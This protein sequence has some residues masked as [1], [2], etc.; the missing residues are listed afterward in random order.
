MIG[1]GTGV[2]SAPIGERVGPG[3]LEIAVE[4]DP[5]FLPIILDN[6]RRTGVSN[7]CAVLR[8]Y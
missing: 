7:V 3:R 1:A 6:A 8:E 5:G 4:V 2:F